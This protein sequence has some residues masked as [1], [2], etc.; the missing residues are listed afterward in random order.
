MQPSSSANRTVTIGNSDGNAIDN[1]IRIPRLILFILLSVFNFDLLFLCYMGLFHMEFKNESYAM[2]SG[3][4]GITSFFLL[5]FWR[6]YYRSEY[7]TLAKR[8]GWYLLIIGIIILSSL[9]IP[10]T[11]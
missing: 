3:W 10:A 11:T 8:T 2:I 7:P 4:I 6:I 9:A 1:K 5:L